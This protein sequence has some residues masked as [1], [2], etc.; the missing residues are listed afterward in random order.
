MWRLR[1]CAWQLRTA[2]GPLSIPAGRPSQRGHR[3]SLPTR[4][5]LLT[6]IS[7]RYFSYLRDGVG[8]GCWEVRDGPV[9]LWYGRTRES[10]QARARPLCP[11]E[12]RATLGG[13]YAAP[14][15]EPASSAGDSLIFCV[16]F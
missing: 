2:P 8:T 11:V 16:N 5:T 14:V 6:R 1:P 9:P 15:L 13:G 12:C 4:Y 3:T 10:E 7:P